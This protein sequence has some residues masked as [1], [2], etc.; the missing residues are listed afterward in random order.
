M[1]K[2]GGVSGGG[3]LPPEIQKMSFEEALKDLEAIVQRLESG[4]ISLEESIEVYSRGTQLK[5][6]CEAKLRAARQRVEKIVA[7]SEG[8]VRAG[9]A[10]IE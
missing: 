9:P 8:E 6:H 4:E 7:D 5:R 1:A 10:G 3:D 2:R